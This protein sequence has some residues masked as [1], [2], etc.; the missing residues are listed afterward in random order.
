[1]A[2]EASVVWLVTQLSMISLMTCQTILMI[3]F[4]NFFQSFDSQP[5]PW[6][7]P[8]CATERRAADEAASARGTREAGWVRRAEASSTAAVGAAWAERTM[9]P[10]P[11]AVMVSSR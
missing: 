7:A 5:A 10:V 9:P 1:M 2:D 6:S 3:T 4:L 8:I 11:T